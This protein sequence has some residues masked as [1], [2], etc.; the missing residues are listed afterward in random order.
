MWVRPV[1][2]AHNDVLRAFVEDAA[3]RVVREELA[4]RKDA[5]L[6]V[7]SVAALL[8]VGRNAVYEA[9]ARREI[10]HRRVGKRIL[11][12]RSALLRWLGC[13]A[14]EKGGTDASTTR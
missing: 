9:C 5:V 3:R 6:D 14:N 11:F 10:P 2:G 1:S 13:D 4:A 12:S 7:D 8:D